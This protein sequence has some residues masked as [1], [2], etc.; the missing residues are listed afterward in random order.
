VP[1]LSGFAIAAILLTT[2]V[3]APMKDAQLVNAFYLG[4]ALPLLV[5]LAVEVV[6]PGRLGALARRLSPASPARA[7]LSA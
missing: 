6:T 7:S 3:I 4:W 5:A 2:H 1:V